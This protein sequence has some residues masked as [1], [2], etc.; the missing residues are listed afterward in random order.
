MV[1]GLIQQYLQVFFFQAE[2]GIRDCLLSRGLGDVYKRQLNSCS[3]MP[4]FCLFRDMFGILNS[5]SEMPCFG[6]FRD[7]FGILNSCSEMPYFGLFRDQFGIL[8]SCSEMP[9]FAQFRKFSEF[10]IPAPKCLILAYFETCCSR[11]L[12]LCLL[13]TSPS[14]RDKRQ[15]RMPSSA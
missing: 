1:F 6:L 13:Y 5:C 15:S 12:I 3:E 7:Q 11:F 14:P 10:F 2:D 8:N 9:H 4:C